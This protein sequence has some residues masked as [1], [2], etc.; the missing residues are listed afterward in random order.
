MR[1]LALIMILF[2]SI[3][4]ADVK[5]GEECDLNEVNSILGDFGSLN[6]L[7][8]SCQKPLLKTISRS[9]EL[10]AYYPHNNKMEGGGKDRFGNR[11]YTL[12]EFL[13]GKAPYVSVAMDYKGSMKKY[14]KKYFCIPALEKSF[15]EEIAQ[16]EKTAPD[17]FSKYGGRIPFKVVDTGS[18]FFNKGLSRMDICVGYHGQAAKSKKL[19]FDPRMQKSVSLLDCDPLFK[20]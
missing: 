16:W 13:D 11:L 8:P 6:T 3:S 17:H 12:Q 7:P 4:Q 10:T 15:S 19:A 5:G 2:T 1:V 18:A 9:T 14:Q 20:H